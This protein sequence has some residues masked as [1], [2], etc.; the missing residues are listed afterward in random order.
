MFIITTMNSAAQEGE[1][2]GGD[3]LEVVP[4]AGSEGG[5]PQE[6]KQEEGRRETFMYKTCKSTQYKTIS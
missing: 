1:L 5:L 4:K 3:H 6:D 2:Q